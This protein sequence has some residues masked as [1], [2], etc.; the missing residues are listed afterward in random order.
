MHQPLVIQCKSCD[1][2]VPIETSTR[3]ETGKRGRP[4]V[5]LNNLFVAACIAVRIEFFIFIF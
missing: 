1:K 2:E 4:E 3:L 5:V